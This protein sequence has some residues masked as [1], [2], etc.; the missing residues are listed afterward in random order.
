MRRKT[1]VLKRR[2]ED[3]GVRT[4]L[5]VSPLAKEDPAITRLA[6]QRKYIIPLDCVVLA[7]RC[8]KHTET[9]WQAHREMSDTDMTITRLQWNTNGD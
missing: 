3:H 4:F 8:G 1:F 7:G 2:R 5:P 9:A 6:R